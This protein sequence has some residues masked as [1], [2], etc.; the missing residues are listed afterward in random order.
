[1]RSP[2]NHPREAERLALLQ[3]CEVLDTPPEQEFDRLVALASAI[4]GTPIALVSLIDQDRQWFKARHGLAAAQTPRE[5]AFCSHA[6]LGSDQTLVVEDARS[7]PRFADNP[8]V[9][10]QPHVI[11]YVGVPLLAGP[12]HL[13]LGTLCVIDH[14]PRVLSGQVLEHLRT[15]ARQVEILLDLRLRHSELAHARLELQRT[16]E[17][18]ALHAKAAAQVEERLRDSLHRFD[19]VVAGAA[20][21]I[22]ETRFDPER[23]STQITNELPFY[24]S[25]RFIE[26]M[27][28]TPDEFPDRLEPWLTAL[29]PDDRE[30]TLAA[31]GDCLANGVPYNVEYR[32][33]HRN[34]DYRWYHATGEAERDELGRPT[35]MAGSMADISA[36]KQSDAEI[37][38]L[39]DQLQDAIESLGAGFV[40]YDADERLVISNRKY[41][42]LYHIAEEFLQPGVRYEDMMRRSMSA[43]PENFR[44]LVG[45]DGIEAFIKKRLLAFRTMQSNQQQKV[46]DRWIQVN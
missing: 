14:T 39:K 33:R 20:I 16:A 5:V 31:V 1:M 44:S 28:Y 17:R 46:G 43:D 11:F 21:G 10:G 8:L 29:H 25:R 24:W 40:M 34:G 35:R 18:D 2:P 27:G 36:R 15:I 32:L 30:H 4:A 6:I 9:R 41:R 22:W 37:H 3:R 42:E 7:D 12:D 26:I 19:L 23:W 38:T 13:P 45:D